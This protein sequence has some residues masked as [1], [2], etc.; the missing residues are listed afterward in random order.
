MTMGNMETGNWRRLN[1][2][3]ATKAFSAV[4]SCPV[5]TYSAKVASDTAKGEVDHTNVVPARER[6]VVFN[7]S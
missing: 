5:S 1:R 4:S 7:R 3:R 6:C 2:E